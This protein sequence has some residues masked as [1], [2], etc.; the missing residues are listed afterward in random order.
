MSQETF[1]L[2][3]TLVFLGAGFGFVA[4]VLTRHFKKEQ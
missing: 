3:L 4:I 2:L 1:D